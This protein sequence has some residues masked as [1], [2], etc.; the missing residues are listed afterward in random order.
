MM[1]ALGIL[2]Y[3]FIAAGGVLLL[4]HV[5]DKHNAKKH[6]PVTRSGTT[7]MYVAPVAA[8]PQY[9]VKPLKDGLKFTTA[10]DSVTLPQF[11]ID[12]AKRDG[13][14]MF[15][16]QLSDSVVAALEDYVKTN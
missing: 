4:Q 7:S 1:L 11:A 3:I 9:S 10:D 2:I 13:V 5:A 14:G 8:K 16:G 12:T 15:R 6:P